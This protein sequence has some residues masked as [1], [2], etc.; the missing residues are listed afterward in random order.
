MEPAAQE[1]AIE[2]AIRTCQQSPDIL[3][4]VGLVEGRDPC[5]S[6][7]LYLPSQTDTG[8]AAVHRAAAIRQEPTK[9]VQQYEPRATAQA[10]IRATMIGLGLGTAKEWYRYFPPCDVNYDGATTA[11]DEFPN[12][13]MVNSGPPGARRRRGLGRPRSN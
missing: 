4:V 8:Q 1:L 2:D 3:D 5:L 7:I 13:S 10:R 12:M 9:L 6:M 11:C